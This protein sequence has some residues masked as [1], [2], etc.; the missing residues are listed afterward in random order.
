MVQI[1]DLSDKHSAAENQQNYLQTGLKMGS[2]LLA[3]AK[4]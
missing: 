2:I 4:S 3:D 1:L